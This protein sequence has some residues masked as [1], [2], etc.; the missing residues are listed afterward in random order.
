MANANVYLDV[1]R[2]QQEFHAHPAEQPV[3]AE[4][5][6]QGEWR[7][8]IENDGKHYIDH[9]CDEHDPKITIDGDFKDWQDKYAFY[10]DVLVK[11]NAHPA[12]QGKDAEDAIPRE[13]TTAMLAVGMNAY[14]RAKDAMWFTVGDTVK[15]VW[16]AMYD[17][18][19]AED[20]EGGK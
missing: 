4:P 18:H 14:A 19:S 3:E 10:T 8:T 5:V 13:P 7:L 20:A 16:Q 17:A 2:K 9:D 15:E 11:L 1:A 6:A 12:E